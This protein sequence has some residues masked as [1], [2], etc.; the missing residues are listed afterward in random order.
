MADLYAQNVADMVKGTLRKLGRRKFQQIAQELTHYEVMSQWLDKDRVVFGDGYGVQ[1]TLMTRTLGSFAHVGLWGTDNVKVGDHL[2]QLKVDWVHAKT[3]WAFERRELL[4]NK[5]ESLVTNIIEPRRAA[6]MIDMVEG[7][8][9]AGFQAATSGSDKTPMGLPH[10]I[11]KN[12][13]TGFNGGYPTG[14]DGTA[15]TDVGT[16]NLTTVPNFKNYTA[17]YT[18]VTKADL[19]KLMRTG[20]REIGFKSP[21]RVINKDYSGASKLRIYMNEATI[22]SMEDL[23]EQQNENLGRD[24]ASFDGEMVFHKIPMVYIPQLKN[25]SDNPIYMVDHSTF[26]TAILKGDYL[27]E[28]DALLVEGSHNAFNVFIDLSYQF[29]CVDRRRNA[30]FSTAASDYI[31]TS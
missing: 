8:E 27:R 30:V 5:G 24:L 20:F 29:F 23:G 15:F 12:A 19:I 13:T 11:V 10:W 3:D 18:N 1:R 17:Q 21:K 6:A 14:P 2:Q 25:D 9:V 4:M 26:K 16:V 22:S 28:S 7:L 31:I